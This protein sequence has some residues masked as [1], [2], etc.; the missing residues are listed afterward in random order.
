MCFY[1]TSNVSDCNHPFVQAGRNKRGHTQWLL[2]F[3]QRQMERDTTGSRVCL[4]R[5]SIQGEILSLQ[6]WGE[7][8]HPGELV[9]ISQRLM[10]SS[11]GM[12]DQNLGWAYSLNYSTDVPTACAQ[13]GAN[14]SALC[15]GCSVYQGKVNNSCHVLWS[16]LISMQERY[17]VTIELWHL[18]STLVRLSS[19]PTQ[20][21]TTELLLQNARE[22]EE[23]G[24]KVNPGSFNRCWKL[25][26]VVNSEEGQESLIPFQG[27]SH[28]LLQ[29]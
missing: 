13:P 22:S 7:W 20:A 19:L 28:P 27:N 29:W 26:T 14:H 17:D 21:G 16:S 3:L 1:I 11:R 18:F 4:R 2:P 12:P 25:R 23:F 15:L 6:Y 8:E 9:V 10:L 24:S 5:T